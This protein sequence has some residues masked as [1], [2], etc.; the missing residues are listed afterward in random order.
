MPGGWGGGG[1]EN[2]RRSGKRW[3]QEFWRAS[4]EKFCQVGDGGRGQGGNFPCRDYFP[5]QERKLDSFPRGKRRTFQFLHL[6]KDSYSPEHHHHYRTLLKKTSPLQRTT[7]KPFPIT[8]H[9]YKKHHYYSTL[10]LKVFII[11]IHCLKAFTGTSTVHYYRKLSLVQDVLK[12]VFTITIYYWKSF[13]VFIIAVQYW[14]TLS[15][16]RRSV[17]KGFHLYSTLV[18]KTITNY[19]TL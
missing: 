14:K 19:R 4:T 15:P 11:T 1:A 18:K 5:R 7:K 6:G 3:P 17:E 12:R 2:W 9:C 16:F 8:G 13:L 10:L